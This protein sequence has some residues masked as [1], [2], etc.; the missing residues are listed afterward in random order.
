MLQTASRIAARSVTLAK[1]YMPQTS[2]N[3]KAAASK[4]QATS[5]APSTINPRLM[6]FVPWFGGLEAMTVVERSR[7]P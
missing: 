2:F 5:K 6:A 7:K 3:S 4:S 1:P